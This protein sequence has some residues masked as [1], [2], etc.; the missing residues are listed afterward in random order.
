MN[1]ATRLL[2][3]LSSDTGRFD[4]E[5][6]KHKGRHRRY[7]TLAIILTALTSIVAASGLVLGP[8][9]GPM[10][11]FAVVVLTAT[12][13]AISAYA[14]SRR[15]RDLWQHER[16]VYYALMDIE[17]E[18]RFMDSV[19]AL[20]EEEVKAYFRQAS[21]VLGSSTAKWSEILKEKKQADTASPSGSG[22]R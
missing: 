16:E 10:I 8:S 11:Q 20:T 5:S 22:V 7:T 17:R 1:A 12:A 19:R 15:F 14:E 3:I 4:E 2:E 18:V 6:Q 13:T 9:R 21:A